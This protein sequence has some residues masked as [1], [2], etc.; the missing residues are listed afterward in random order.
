MQDGTYINLGE[1]QF[2]RVEA[3]RGYWVAS[4]SVHPMEIGTGEFI[5]IWTD[6]ETGQTW[7]DRTH[8]F[9]SLSTALAFAQR[10][11]QLAIWDCRH[12]KEIRL[13]I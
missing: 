2:A 13:D 9:S 7:Y 10:H 4:E 11:D 1:S 6:T 12:A 3:T 8:W 5:G